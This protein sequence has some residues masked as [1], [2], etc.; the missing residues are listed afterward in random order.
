METPSRIRQQIA[1][2][3]A[4]IMIEEGIGQYAM[5]KKKAL[6]RLALEGNQ[7]LPSNEE[8]D[9]ALQEYHRIFRF[10]KQPQFIR[11]L[12]RIALETMELFQDF[13]PRLTGPV[14]EGTAG[15]HSPI[16]L[17][18]FPET[19]EEVLLKINQTGIPFK[20]R[21]F[22]EA[23][24]N[25]KTLKIPVIELCREEQVVKIFLYPAVALRQSPKN[26]P[27]R[28]SLKK[29]RKLLANQNPQGL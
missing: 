5:A 17:H 15:D 13:S 25:S 12:R 24:L 14:L 11:R 28:A 8:I 10:M 19:P 6:H 20:E 3:C 1:Q 16:L 7:D 26:A 18:L 22:A 29:L 9:H 21:P 27:P 2:V 4:R 23:E